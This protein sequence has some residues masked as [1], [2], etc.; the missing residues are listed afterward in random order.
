M[1]LALNLQYKT[2]CDI[3]YI[4]SHYQKGALRWQP[5]TSATSS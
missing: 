4:S 5:T 1:A 2:T 3:L